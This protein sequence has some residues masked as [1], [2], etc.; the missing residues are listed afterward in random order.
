MSYRAVLFDAGGTLVEPDPSFVE[1]FAIICRS[2][3]APVT[4][5]QVETVERRL[6]SEVLKPRSRVPYSSSPEAS[7]AFWIWFYGEFLSALG[8]GGRD[9]IV[10]ELYRVFSSP[11]T[12][13][14][15]PDVR[16]CL[17]FLQKK[18]MVMGIVSN[19]ERWLPDLLEQVGIAGYFSTIIVS[20]EVGVEKP[21]PRI[22]RL[23][24]EQLAIS[25]E[26][27]LYVGDILEA[28]ILPALEVGMTPILIDRQGKYP[29]GVPCCRLTILTDLPSIFAEEREK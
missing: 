5:T 1:R 6:W 28:D 27:V 29:N 12:Y 21:D 11:Q 13:R 4:P 9:D 3:G 18:G 14:L 15:F 10:E 23:A 8:L 20:G 16:P 17:E 25:P 7:R 19:W 22:F 24:L 2:L 26:Q